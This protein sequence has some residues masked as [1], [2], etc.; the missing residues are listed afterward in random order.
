M[1]GTQ[2]GSRLQHTTSK[3]HT[4]NVRQLKKNTMVTSLFRQQNVKEDYLTTAAE[5][6]YHGVKL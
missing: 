2:I 5:V 1:V 4:K 3:K 6:S